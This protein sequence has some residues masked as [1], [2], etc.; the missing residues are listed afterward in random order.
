[1]KAM[2]EIVLEGHIIDSWILPRVFDKIMDMGGEFEVVDFQ[3]GTHK[4]AH[5]RTRILI[6]GKDETHADAILEELHRLGANLPEVED[7]RIETA[8]ADKVVPEGF[9]STTNHDTY[10]KLDGKW[11]QARNI[12]MDRLIVIREG[13]PV[14]EPLAHIRKGDTVIVGEQGVRVIP[15]ERPRERTLFEFMGGGASPE[16]P[17]ANLIKQIADEMR[18]IRSR[19]GRIAIVAGPAV[20]HTG[21]SPALAQMIR[22]GH[23]DVLLS[24]NALAVHDIEYNLYGTSLGM[25]IENGE[26]ASSGHKHHIYAISKIMACG[27]IENA[28]KQGTLK[29]GIMYECI[30]N[31]IPFVLAGSIRDDGP[32]PEVI[33]DTMEAKDAMKDALQGADMVIM[34]ATM[35]HSI[36]AGNLLLSKVKTICVD[37]NPSAVTKLTDRG[38]AQAVGIVTDVGAFLPALADALGDK[39]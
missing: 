3:I 12:S 22:G 16:R 37:I 34:A 39:D 28:V 11:K 9:Y 18:Q 4:T 10:V 17:S 33:T 27:S 25:N 24:G 8:P 14:C 36:A 2:R 29:G 5:S 35:L 1:M 38:T 13:E 20:V 15:P 23:V 21:A 32:L 19:G 7:A 31:R 6:T 30:K 26:L